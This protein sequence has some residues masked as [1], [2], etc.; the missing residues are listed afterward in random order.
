MHNKSGV[1][2]DFKLFQM[3]PSAL[4][5]SKWAFCGAYHVFFECH[6]RYVL[7]ET[8]RSTGWKSSKHAADLNQPKHSSIFSSLCRIFHEDLVKIGFGEN[9]E[10]QK[11]PLVSICSSSAPL[12]YA[13]FLY[14]KHFQTP[15][16]GPVRL[17][18]QRPD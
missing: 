7:T 13:I 2:F 10:H 18:N 6:R 9:R 4:R 5:I 3:I 1:C 16:S 11:I 12:V 17:S 15:K 8:N 14:P